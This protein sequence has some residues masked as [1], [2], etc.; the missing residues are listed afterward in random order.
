LA[1]LKKG[2]LKATGHTSDG[3]DAMTFAPFCEM[4]MT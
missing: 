3:T 1:V 4:S 2:D